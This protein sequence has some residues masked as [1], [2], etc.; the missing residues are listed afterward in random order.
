MGEP[1]PGTLVIRRRR[2]GFYLLCAVLA[3]AA[4]WLATI[5]LGHPLFDVGIQ[6]TRT[7]RW[8]AAAGAALCVALA[9]ALL[10][11][12]RN[13]FVEIGPDRV[14]LHQGWTDHVVER[15]DVVRIASFDPPDGS[16][17]VVLLGETGRPLAAYDDKEWDGDLPR[18]FQEQWGVKVPYH[19]HVVRGD[20]KQLYPHVTWP[21]RMFARSGGG[22]DGGGDGGG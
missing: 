14:R 9:G 8:V 15:A 21:R 17:R 6:Q 7:A 12:A 13:D 10:S 1:V 20:M 22:G 2:G 18:A 3:V 19:G 11:G 5:A 16:Y 4:T